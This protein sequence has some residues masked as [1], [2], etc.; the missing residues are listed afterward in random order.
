MPSALQREHPALQNMISLLFLLP[1][2]V[3]FALMDADPAT[4][5]SV[6]LCGSGSE[7]LGEQPYE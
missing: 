3:T 5:I 4:Q 2:W 7:T 6:D 1:L